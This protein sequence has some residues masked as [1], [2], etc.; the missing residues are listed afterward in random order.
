[1]RNALQVKIDGVTYHAVIKELTVR[2]S[3]LINRMRVA[4][5]D[6]QLED[7][8]L[9]ALYDFPLMLFSL[10]KLSKGEDEIEFSREFYFNLTENVKGEWLKRIH[11]LNPLHA[12]LQ[13]DVLKKIMEPLMQNSFGT[14]EHKEVE[15]QS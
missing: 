6:E 13:L 8:E 9:L 4:I 11:S 7:Q 3:M 15:V 1:M 10:E 5:S 14:K 2:D 12:P